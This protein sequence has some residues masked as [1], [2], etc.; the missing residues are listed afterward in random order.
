M[1]NVLHRNIGV[2][3][4]HPPLGAKQDTNDWALQLLSDETE[5]YRIEFSDGNNILQID[6][7]DNQVTWGY[8]TA[9]IDYRFLSNNG[10]FVTETQYIGVND[11]QSISLIDGGFY[12]R[13]TASN[14]GVVFWDQ[15]SDEWAFATAT[16]VPGSDDITINSY[17]PIHPEY[18]QLHPISAPG[19]TFRVYCVITDL[20]FE[21]GD[22]NSIKITS[23]GA[24]NAVGGGGGGVADL[25]E[26]YDADPQIILDAT[27]ALDFQHSIAAATHSAVEITYPATAFTGTPSAVLVD[28]S[29]ATSFSNAGD[30][31]GVNLLGDTNAGGGDSVGLNVDGNWDK[32]I[33]NASTYEQT[34]DAFTFTGSNFDLDPT[35]T[36]ALDMDASQTATVTLADNLSSALLVQETANAYIKVDTNDGSETVE[37]GNATTDP[38]YS[39][40][41]A[42]DWTVGGSVGGSGDVLTS[43]GA[44]AAP[45]WQTP[46]TPGA[47]DLQEA[48]DAD[49]QIILDATGALDF[50]H[51]VAAATHPVIDIT[52]P[53]TAFTGTPHALQVDLT[54]ATSFNNAGDIYG[55]NMLGATNAGAGEGVGI[56]FDG[57]WDEE[58]QFTRTSPRITGGNVL[59][60]VNNNAELRLTQTVSTGDALVVYEAG[61]FG[62]WA[63]G[64]DNSDPNNAFTFSQG[65][66]VGGNNT[67]RIGRGGNWADF[68]SSDYT[69]DDIAIGGGR[70]DQVSP[71]A[72]ATIRGTNASGSNAGTNVTITG[73]TSASG[74]NGHVIT[75]SGRTDYQLE[76]EQSSG[77]CAILYDGPTDWVAG[78]DDSDSDAFAIESATAL[79]GAGELRIFPGGGNVWGTAV[80]DVTWTNASK[81]VT[82]GTTNDVVL[83]IDVASGEIVIATAWVIATDG[84]SEFG[85]IKITGSAVNVGGTTQVISATVSTDEHNDAEGAIDADFAVND[86]ADTL[87]VQCDALAGTNTDFYIVCMYF[88]RSF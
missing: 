21:D 18:V 44:S 3:D 86:T 32:G 55:L 61:G 60:L 56:R 4:M 49:P 36:F 52:Y 51:S 76:V 46:A 13:R 77:D 20:Y 64:L 62:F 2:A 47:A 5:A 45:T 50:Q 27:G 23:D 6:T 85:A 78:V 15:S 8:N 39:W 33:V 11:S 14:Y 84:T 79:T 38:S 26:A 24:V 75:T 58:I 19:G 40:L 34:A 57:N 69:V 65:T 25:Q 31:L 35:G 28:L 10:T 53:A 41:G 17:D 72:N 81:T 68:G 48:Y 63:A 67:F 54:G 83:S 30:I 22:G 71:V 82:S 87:E 43:N 1:V 74:T 80:G 73:G 7:S 37:M 88:R 12:H 42:G 29:G 59:R 66:Q 9:G 70:V 16:T